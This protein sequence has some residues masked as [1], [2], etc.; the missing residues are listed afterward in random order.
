MRNY[1]SPLKAGLSTPVGQ[2][3][4]AVGTGAASL[5]YPSDPAQGF[6]E[7]SAKIQVHQGS[8]DTAK[9]HSFSVVCVTGSNE[10]LITN[11]YPLNGTVTLHYDRTNL[12]K[13]LT[14]TRPIP[15]EVAAIVDKSFGAS[16]PFEQARSKITI[17]VRTSPTGKPPGDDAGMNLPWLAFCSG[18]FFR[19]H[20]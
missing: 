18:A 6:V 14:T 9:V 8:N 4:S 5:S 13:R 17:Q 20:D 3:Q 7:I 15:V 12:C 16:V 2:G 1:L 11:D 19:D 10:W